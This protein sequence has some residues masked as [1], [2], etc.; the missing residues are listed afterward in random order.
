M[1]DEVFFRKYVEIPFTYFFQGLLHAVPVY[2]CAVVGWFLELW[3]EWFL[4][5][6]RHSDHV[7][8]QISGS[9]FWIPEIAV[10]FFLG[11]L[12]YGFSRNKATMLGWLLP[13]VLLSWAVAFWPESGS[14]AWDAF[15][16]KDC[17]MSECL[18]QPILT[19]PFYTGAA[20]SFGALL[21]FFFADKKSSAREKDLE[22][23]I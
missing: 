21:I 18:Y 10:G 13:A 23:G 4:T 1:I 15:F 2:I 6:T 16:S 14:S 5:F 22:E 19:V 9:P 17:G 8:K 20:Y 3:I 7:V 11:C 12:I